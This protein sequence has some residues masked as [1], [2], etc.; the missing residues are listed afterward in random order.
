MQVASSKYQ[1]AGCKIQDAISR[2]QVA[3]YSLRDAHCAVCGTRAK[4]FWVFC[5]E[6]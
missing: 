1:V 5:L 2:L 4:S 3:G 6:I